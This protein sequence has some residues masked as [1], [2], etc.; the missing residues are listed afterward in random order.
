MSLKRVLFFLAIGL[1]YSYNAHAAKPLILTDT[2]EYTPLGLHFDILE[3][4]DGKVTI[5]E[6]D[7]P[8]MNERFMPGKSEIY[9][10]GSTTSIFW[11]RLAIEN[12]TKKSINGVIEMPIAWAD[13]IEF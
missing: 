9:S 1:L 3:D 6:I 10:M 5:D 7:G 8:A 11:L 13:N 2:V 12:I 4:V